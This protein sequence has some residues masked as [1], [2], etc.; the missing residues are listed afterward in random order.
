M[1]EPTPETGTSSSAQELIISSSPRAV[2]YEDEK[3]YIGIG[4]TPDVHGVAMKIQRASDAYMAYAEVEEKPNKVEVLSWYFYEFCSY[5]ILTVLIPIVFPL[6][7]SQVANGSLA[8]VEG[9]FIDKGFVCKQKEIKLYHSLTKKS[10]LSKYSALEW[11]SI[12]WAIGLALASPLLGFVSII[13]D[14]GYNQP[15]IAAAATA[16]GAI[17]CLPAGFFKTL[18]IFPPYIAAITA[19]HIISHR[20]PHPPPWPNAAAGSLGAAIMSSFTYHML[21]EEDEYISLWVVSIFSGIKW[22]CGIFHFVVTKRPCVNPPISKSHAL[23]IFKFPHAVGGLVG[24]FLSSAITMCLFTGGVLYL[25]GQLCYDPRSLLYLWLMYFIFPLFSLPMLQPLQHFIKANAVKMQL[26]GFFLSLTTSGYGFYFGSSVWE[27]RHVLLFAAVQSTSAGLL[28]A[29]G[30]VLLM[31]CSP[32]GKEGAFSA[33]FSWT[34]ALGTC[35]GFAVASAIPGN[36]STSFG[37]SFITAVCGVLVLI[38]GN[39]SDS[40]GAKAAGHVRHD[41][42]EGGSPVQGLDAAAAAYEMQESAY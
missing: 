40:G 29:F 7:I 15:I 17:F 4:T 21:R 28:H 24:A 26:M 11:T 23:S 25:V 9:G 38:F 32:P 5:F 18:W 35:A 20:L 31:D 14:H 8:S 27:Q 16:I 36:V 37:L 6:I 41:S 13:L 10:I 19:A 39:I 42:E 22:L 3:A 30:R 34:K 12:S 1:A 33:W 2:E